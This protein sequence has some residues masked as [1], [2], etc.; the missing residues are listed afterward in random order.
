MPFVGTVTEDGLFFKYADII[1]RFGDETKLK[2]YLKKQHIIEIIGKNHKFAPKMICAYRTTT[3]GGDKYLNFP[4][5]YINEFP[6]TFIE[7]L[8]EF[9]YP[10][11]VQH[12]EDVILSPIITFT[13]YQ[14]VAVDHIMEILP[15]K[16][17]AYINLPTGLGKTI[18]AIKIIVSLQVATLVVVPTQAIAIQWIT[19]AR[20]VYPD[21]TIS[22][23]ENKN[24]YNP[25]PSNTFITVVIINT[26]SKKKHDFLAGYGLVVIDEV[27]EYSHPTGLESLWLSQAVPYIIGLSATPFQASHG[28][29][30]IVPKFIGEPIDI[31]KLPGCDV[32]DVQ[33]KVKV[34]T[35]KYTGDPL[36]T[37]RE[38]GSA[39]TIIPIN[40]I[41]KFIE[42]PSRVKL[43][44]GE[45]KRLRAAGHG[46]FVFAE[47]RSYLAVLRDELLQADIGEDVVIADDED[48]DIASTTCTACTASTGV[49]VLQGG[50]S[51]Q[52]LDS[53]KRAGVHIVLTT[54]GYSRR[55]ISLVE[56]TALVL[57][58]PRKSNIIQIIGRILR[59][60]SDVTKEREIVDVVDVSSGLQGQYNVRKSK[61]NELGYPITIRH[62]S[63][64]PALTPIKVSPKLID[65]EAM[66]DKAVLGNY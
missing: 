20:K 22:Q 46:V 51:A 65:F 15:T 48:S 6:K 33:Y 60:G 63:F 13:Q 57:T 42:D 18:L 19:D 38:T 62:A 58:T 7:R 32:I 37:I 53:A 54:Y 50:I 30:Y 10:P 31:V 14:E 3:L 26:Y 27:H 12:E 36:Y 23:Y 11:I 59:R 4:R 17:V 66:Y 40:T 16:K 29:D 41:K 28:L 43:I 52:Q 21:I 24:R 34:T 49:S 45:I 44:V 25:T 56:M 35:I 55:G 39:G 5:N 47:L 2:R 64:D 61:Y 9:E 8:D 1:K